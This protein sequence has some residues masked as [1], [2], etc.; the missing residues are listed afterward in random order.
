M[1]RLYQLTE[2]WYRNI[3]LLLVPC[4]NSLNSLAEALIRDKEFVVGRLYK[5]YNIP[6]DW[7]LVPEYFFVAGTV[8]Q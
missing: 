3:S 5:N 8:Y 2:G 4:T 6:V 1:E 7:G